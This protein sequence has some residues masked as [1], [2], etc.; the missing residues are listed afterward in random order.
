MKKLNG[1]KQQIAGLLG[2]DVVI[3][4]KEQRGKIDEHTGKIDKVFGAFFNLETSGSNRQQ[5]SFTFAD[6]LTNEIIVHS[7]NDENIVVKN[8]PE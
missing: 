1:I 6:I 7:K 3:F 4:T 5:L 2:Q 8:I